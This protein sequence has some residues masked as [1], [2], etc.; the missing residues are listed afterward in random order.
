MIAAGSGVGRAQELD[1]PFGWIE[2]GEHC[3]LRARPH[4]DVTGDQVELFARKRIEPRRLAGRHQWPVCR[5]QRPTVP[6]RRRPATD[7]VR[8]QLGLAGETLGAH[9][10]ACPASAT[11]S[12]ALIATAMF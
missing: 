4:G 2:D 1:E 9:L 11:P 6:F 8:R 12:R 5:N 7:V 3:R 10:I